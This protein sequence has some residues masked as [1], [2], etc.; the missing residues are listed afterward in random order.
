MTGGRVVDDRELSSSNWN[1][2]EKFDD[3]KHK[4]KEAPEGELHG[5]TITSNVR[6]WL[7]WCEQEDVDVTTANKTDLQRHLHGIYGEVADPSF[8][9]RVN[10]IQDFY[11]WALSLGLVE[12]NPTANFT[13]DDSPFD[14]RSSVSQ[15]KVVLSPDSDAEDG[16][17]AILAVSPDVVDRT[18]N[19]TESDRDELIVR[20]LYQTGV[21]AAEL[22]DIR[23]KDVDQ[24][25]RRIKIR[26]VKTETDADNYPRNVYWQPSLDYLMDAWMRRRRQYTTCDSH[27]YDEDENKEDPTHLF[28]SMH[29]DHIKSNYISRIV[30]EA[31]I[32]AGVNET[33]YQ[34]AAGRDRWL[35]TAHTLRHS[36][37]TYMANEAEV[38]IHI[39]ADL[40]GHLSLDTTRKYISS[41]EETLRRYAVNNGPGARRDAGS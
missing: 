40:M 25:H 2:L 4:N 41:D 23:I 6:A 12:N 1:L 37:A 26:T 24:E 7:R 19:H 9:A 34:D 38:P 5:G 17:N 33:M 14:I 13:I 35:I 20:L 39:L 30:K 3:F 16:E 22:E 21:R 36:F 28:L 15:K 8:G 27:K 32:R 31:A 10:G 18:A 29:N 11:V